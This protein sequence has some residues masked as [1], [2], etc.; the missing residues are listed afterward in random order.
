MNGRR[1]AQYEVL[2][3]IG[4]GGMGEVWRARD[5]RLARDVALKF[6]PPD[7]A[8]DPE[9]VAR[10]R[11]EARVLAALNHGNIAAVHGLEES[12]GELVLAMEYVD[13]EDLSERLRRAPLD[14]DEVL[15]LAR[16]FAEGLEAAHER[17]IVHR[18]L[19]PANLKITADGR[20]KILDFGLARAFGGDDG[21]GGSSLDS[22][23]LTAPLTQKGMILGTAAYMSPEQARGRSVDARTDI[24]AF[25]VILYEMLTGVRLFHGETVS[26]TVAAVLRADLDLTDLP[27][28]TPAGV[29]RLLRR[30]LERDARRR[31]RDIGEARV[32]LERW[33][34]DPDSIHESGGPSG[35][36]MLA[37]RA[38]RAWLPWT[39]AAVAVCAAMVLGWRQLRAPAAAPR[40]GDW[41]LELPGEA[42]ISRTNL[43]NVTVSPDGHWFCWLT[44]DGIRVRAVDGQDVQLL[45][46]TA[47]VLTACFSPDSRW[48]AFV[49]RNGLQR[50]SVS[51]GSPFR[52]TSADLTRG[53]AWV[54]AKTIVLCPGI[55]TGLLAVDVET[56]EVTRLTEPDKDKGERSHRWPTAV[57]GKRG[58]LFEVQHVGRDYDN[59]DIDYLD[60]DTGERR[61]VYRGGAAPLARAAGHLL[62]V[63]G[64][65]IFAIRLDLGRMVTEGLPVAVRDH[66]LAS[67]GNQEDDDG[68]ANYALDDAG[69][70]FYLDNLGGGEE[71]SRLAWL[72]LSDGSIEPFSDFAAYGG[73]FRVSPDGRLLATAITRDGDRNL[74]V[75]DLASGNEQ[76]LTNR[77]SVEYPGA[78]SPDSRRF[79]WTQASDDGSRFEIWSRLVDGSRPAE[80]VATPA[81]ESGSWVSSISPN[82]RFLMGDCVA[83]GNLY[84]TFVLDLDDSTRTCLPGLTGPEYERNP[85]FVGDGTFFAYDLGNNARRQIMIRRFPDTGA[86]W[87]LPAAPAGWRRCHWSAA[88]GGAIARDDNG[89]FLLPVQQDGAALKIGAPR[90]LCDPR[91]SALGRLI[92]AWDV[93][94]DGR[95]LVVMLQ[96]SAD[97]AAEGPSLAVVTG[98]E[99]TVVRRLRDARD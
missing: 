5:T 76:L 70:L 36:H 10:F 25:G 35:T 90:L 42:D 83:G 17:G 69:D 98:W 68:S 21:D 22:P 20:L 62:F 97:T 2:E 41:L 72:T 78:W 14:R 18:D 9:R 67:V 12:D 40:V 84:D 29:R 45:P 43:N 56:G 80:Y 89:F 88:A 28:D 93:H 65:S 66:V 32:R 92:T 99:R 95:R 16:Q 71:K 48:I 33:R 44:A 55:V 31:L 51:G 23:T 37:P 79:Y 4:Q 30:C 59:S 54:D 7:F 8:A 58:V 52:L 77:V 86:V 13:G 81:S 82:G 60:L 26:D 87:S 34:E 96:Q 64:A 53:V 61:T 19:K 11:N 50:I 3:K 94:P 46:E 74:Y 91:A 75:R 57:P 1:I 24:W 85:G 63:R 73:E 15:D 39:V 47:G 27:A 49:G 38:R 6:L